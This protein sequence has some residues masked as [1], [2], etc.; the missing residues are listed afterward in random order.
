[1]NTHEL[2][3][4]LLKEPAKNITASVD[5]STGDNDEFNRV[6][7]DFCGLQYE[8]GVVTLLFDNGVFNYEALL[9]IPDIKDNPLTVIDALRKAD[10]YIETLFLEGSCYQFYLFL[11]KLYPSATPVRNHDFTHVG[12]L[13][14]GQCY[15]ITGIV[16]WSYQALNKSEIK[17][18]EEWSFAKKMF[19]SLGE[20]PACEE[21]LLVK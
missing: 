14:E 13:I 11:K 9:P 18:A 17:Q 4:M 5:T 3:A 16:N 10:P 20:C 6:F 1:M 2:A 7:G 21:P 8:D 19:L 12:A 15:D